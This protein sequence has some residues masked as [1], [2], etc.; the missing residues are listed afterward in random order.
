[1][2]RVRPFTFF[3]FSR[4]SQKTKLKCSPLKEPRGQALAFCFLF[5]CVALR[6]CNLEET[7]GGLNVTWACFFPVYG[8]QRIAGWPL[9]LLLR[10]CQLS[11]S[12]PTVGSGAPGLAGL[13]RAGCR[14]GAAAVPQQAK[15]KRFKGFKGLGAKAVGGGGMMDTWVR[16]CNLLHSGSRFFVGLFLA[17]PWTPG[18]PGTRKGRRDGHH[19]RVMSKHV[20]D[21]EPMKT[22]SPWWTGCLSRLEVS[23]LHSICVI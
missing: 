14:G 8:L 12:C 5:A 23:Q 21:S 7:P 19:H 2:W 20:E 17:A 16:F 4:A 10:Y 1:M 3:S 22:C 11:F 13:V 18:G 15:Q 6:T 9:S